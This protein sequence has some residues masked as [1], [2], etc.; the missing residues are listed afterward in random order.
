M[1]RQRRVSLFLSSPSPS[2]FLYK[3]VVNSIIYSLNL[4]AGSDFISTGMSF[5]CLCMYWVCVSRW[6]FMFDWLR[7]FGFFFF[8]IFFCFILLFVGL[9]EELRYWVFILS[10][11]TWVCRVC[12]NRLIS[13]LISCATLFFLLF[14]HI[15]VW[16][17]PYSLF[18][19]VEPGLKNSS[20]V[21]R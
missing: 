10:I 5:F 7:L 19:L 20:L 4:I 8:L 3:I 15:L 6:K 16:F 18:G 12:T 21:L 17:K 11:W 1:E 2:L 13:N 14:S 9:S